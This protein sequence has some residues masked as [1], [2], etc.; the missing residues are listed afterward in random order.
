MPIKTINILHGKRQRV[1]MK[2]EQEVSFK[3]FGIYE[4]KRMAKYIERKTKE[5]WKLEW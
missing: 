1:T 5:G 4:G 2:K 3:H